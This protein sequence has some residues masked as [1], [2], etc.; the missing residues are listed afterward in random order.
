MRTRK[1]IEDEFTSKGPELATEI[2]KMEVLL[3][4]M[5]LLEKMFMEQQTMTQLV[6]NI[7][8]KE[9]TRI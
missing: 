3:N 2:L 8:N 6:R 1:E 9:Q 5:E 4:I 7:N